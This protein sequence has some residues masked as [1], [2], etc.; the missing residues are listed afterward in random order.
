MT[1]RER[2][3]SMLNGGFRHED[4]RVDFL[5]RLI[6]VAEKSFIEVYDEWHMVGP[7]H[8]KTYFWLYVKKYIDQRLAQAKKK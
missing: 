5:I 8:S 4:D 3:E 1:A 7:D 6:E 2:F